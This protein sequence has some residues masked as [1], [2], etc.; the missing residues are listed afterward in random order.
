MEESKKEMEK[1]IQEVIEKEIEKGVEK[2]VARGVAFLVGFAVSFVITLLVFKF[3]WAWVVGDLFPGA[4]A[5]GLISADLAFRSIDRKILDSIRIAYQLMCMGHAKA[6]ACPAKLANRPP[7]RKPQPCSIILCRA[8]AANTYGIRPTA[9][10]LMG[11]LTIGHALSSG[12]D[13]HSSL[14]I[15][16]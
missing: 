5:E 1:E 11:H 16:G 2:G 15:K 4:V 3:M 10:S 12:V 9:I 14:L 7:A 8:A 6:N 13:P